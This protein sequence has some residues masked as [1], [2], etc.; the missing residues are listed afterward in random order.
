MGKKRHILKSQTFL[1]LALAFGILNN[2]LIETI[3]RVGRTLFGFPVS[4][5]RS[6]I[7]PSFLPPR[8]FIRFFPS[9][10]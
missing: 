9:K 1:P 10:K 7:I 3:L 8:L 2:F 4:F 5:P 6:A